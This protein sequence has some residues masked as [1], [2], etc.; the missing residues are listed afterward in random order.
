METL[1]ERFL[2]E[3]GSQI[4]KVAF[5]KNG[6]WLAASDDFGTPVSKKLNLISVSG[7]SQIQARRLCLPVT[8]PTSTTSHSLM[9]I[10]SWQ[11]RVMM[12]RCDYGMLES[13]RMFPRRVARFPAWCIGRASVQMVGG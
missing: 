10:H 6:E 11:V 4:S 13:P 12:A 8:L 2:L 5:S 3:C 1:Q 7:V 9:M